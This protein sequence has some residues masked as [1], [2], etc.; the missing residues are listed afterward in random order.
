MFVIPASEDCVWDE[1]QWEG[2]GVLE[3]DASMFDPLCCEGKIDANPKR[4]AISHSVKI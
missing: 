2:H 4:E 1:L 3:L